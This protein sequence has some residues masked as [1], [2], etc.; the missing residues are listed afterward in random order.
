MSTASQPSILYLVLDYRHT[1]DVG[2]FFKVVPF[3][4][5]FSFYMS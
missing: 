1:P 2:A 3:E 4:F 5:P